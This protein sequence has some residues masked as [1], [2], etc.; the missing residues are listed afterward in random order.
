M[1]TEPTDA[2]DRSTPADPTG[3]APAARFPPGDM[4]VVTVVVTGDV[5]VLVAGTGAPPERRR[6]H[7]LE[8]V[9]LKS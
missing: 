8:N 9:V 6:G 7:A 3:H 2:S 4:E 1:P 5:V